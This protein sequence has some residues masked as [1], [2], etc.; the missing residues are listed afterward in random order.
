MAVVGYL[1]LG[2]RGE[3]ADDAGFDVNE[4][5]QGQA[6]SGGPVARRQSSSLGMVQGGSEY[7][8][9]QSRGPAAAPNP[10]DKLK[11]PSFAQLYKDFEKKITAM[12]VEYEKKYPI[13][14]QYGKEWV[15]HPDLRKL[16]DDYRKDHD[17]AKFIKGLVNAPNFGGMVKKYAGQP[18][19][20]SFAQDAFKQAP[21][22]VMSAATEFLT[23]ED[24]AKN[25]VRDTMQSMGMPIG[26]A[27]MIAGDSNAKID[28]GQIMGQA[29][30]GMSPPGGQPLPPPAVPDPSRQR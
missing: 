26:V 10:T 14:T 21:P 22:E 4:V 13:L 27:A 20:T 5:A 29:L 16:R 11:D 25:L 1:L 17:P 28:S 30:Q 8:Q 23:K 2:G 15:S 18:P 12:V 9:P 24:T 3:G 7:A 19:F 6:T